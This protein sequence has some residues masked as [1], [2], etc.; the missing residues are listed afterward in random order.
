MDTNDP[1]PLFTEF[2]KDFKLEHLNA[3][4]RADLRKYLSRLGRKLF[5]HEQMMKDP[6]KP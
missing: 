6:R 3:E 2:L 5:E 1:D 4:E